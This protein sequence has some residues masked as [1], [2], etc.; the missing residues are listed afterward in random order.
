MNLFKKLDR[1]GQKNIDEIFNVCLSAGI[2]VALLFL[3]NNLQEICKL[4]KELFS[5]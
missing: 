1:W 3:I 4:F 2:I 5:Q